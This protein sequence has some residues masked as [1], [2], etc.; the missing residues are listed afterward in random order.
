[1]SLE[2]EL[3]RRTSLELSFVDK[4]TRDIFDDTCAGNYPIPQSGA[5]C[6]ALTIANIPQAE[7]DYRAWI[8]RFE[9][10]ALD[11][12]HVLASYTYSEAKGSINWS[13]LD[14]IDFDEYPY[15]FDNRYGY[16]DNHQRHRIKVN[17]YVLLPWKLDLAFSGLWA[18]PW[19]WTPY[20]DTV[21]GMLR[22]WAFVEPRGSRE[23]S[24]E[25]RLDLQLG[26]AF[27]VGRF[28][29]KLIGS[30]I[31]LLDS[32]NSEAVCEDIEGC[33]EFALGDAIEWQQPRYFELG[34]RLEF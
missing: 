32:E 34:L 13:G 7:R 2:R 31:N 20:D 18:S 26:K 15:H 4:I 16:L 28:R 12:L 3:L 6:S 19:R 17:G 27:D 10:R 11:R 8:L 22:G 1:M 9:S 33:G 14:S 5:D 29:I 21:E 24:N 23:G 30:V 25:T